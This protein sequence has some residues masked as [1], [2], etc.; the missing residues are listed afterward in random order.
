MPFRVPADGGAQR[1]A[2]PSRRRW[3]GLCRERERRLGGDEF[4]ILLE[5]GRGGA[6]IA[7][8]RVA[9]ALTGTYR[10]IGHTVPLGVSVGVAVRETGEELDELMRRAD[11]AMYTAKAT[12]EGGWRLFDPDVDLVQR[13]AQPRRVELEPVLERE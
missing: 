1:P 4:G 12:G 11:A 7:A 10:V 8:E 6:T 2:R 5:E 3:R 13:S 9:R